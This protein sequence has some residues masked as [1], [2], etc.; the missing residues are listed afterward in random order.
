M[1]IDF[2]KIEGAGND[3][4]L[5][6]RIDTG[7]ETIKWKKV[8]PSLCRRKFGIGAD[9]VLVLEPHDDS[10]FK[11][12]IFNPDGGEVS[13]CGNGARCSAYYYFSREEVSSTKFCTGAGIM[14][15][16]ASKKG[17]IRLSMTQPTGIELDILIRTEDGELSVS[18]IDTG[19]PHVVV[20]TEKLDSLDVEKLGRAIRHN[21][22]FLPEGTNADFLQ[23]TG[24]SSLEVRTYE[25][26]VEGET[27]ACGTGA[28]ASAIIA[29]L[30][31]KVV[32]PVDI[33]TRGGD[34]M[35]VY[36]QKSDDEDLISRIYDVKLEGAVNRVFT[37][38]FDIDRIKTGGCDV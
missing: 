17:R 34:V 28:V 24:K 22:R 1:N 31:N 35:K 20:E 26:G 37:G 30:K 9:G 12:R 15:A 23:V 19:V 21:E 3:F 5:I 10:D 7:S 32:P 16:E 36:F 8:V 6:D 29:S 27:L 2:V 38:S 13:M 14:R 18:F 33:K 25:R 4:V 11:M